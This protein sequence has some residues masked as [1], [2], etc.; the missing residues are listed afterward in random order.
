MS[1]A[2]L[3]LYSTLYIKCDTS[4]FQRMVIPSHVKFVSCIEWDA[5]LPPFE[6][7]KDETLFAKSV[8][9]R[10]DLT[11]SEHLTVDGQKYVQQCHLEQK[12]LKNIQ[13]AFGTEFGGLPVRPEIGFFI[14]IPESETLPITDYMIMS[15]SHRN[16]LVRFGKLHAV[17]RYS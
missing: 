6:L 11:K 17:L 13:D 10:I 15:L 1:L 3:T 12:S 2:S 9:G 14:R 8:H 16:I 5:N 4:R 7:Y